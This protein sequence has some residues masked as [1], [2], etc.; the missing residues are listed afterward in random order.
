MTP[1]PSG[2]NYSYFSLRGISQ[3]RINITLDGAPLNDPAEHAVYFNNFHDFTSAVDSIQIQRGVGTS[4]VGS[5][6]Y[7]GSISFASDSWMFSVPVLTK[8]AMIPSA[9]PTSPTR[10][11]MNAFLLASA[12]VRLRYQKPISR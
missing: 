2:T 7:G 5:P 9:K 1:S 12:A 4:T 6:A 11:V 10:F 3:S 8:I